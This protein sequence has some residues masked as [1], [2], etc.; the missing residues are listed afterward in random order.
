M[1]GT[2]REVM[3]GQAECVQEDETVL[4]A[5]RTTS[6]LGVGALPIGDDDRLEGVLPDRDI[7]LR[8]PVVDEQQ[9]AGVLSGALVAEDATP[10]LVVS[11]VHGVR[12]D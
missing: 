3:T 10:E 1:E 6:Q 5:D 9:L 8:L 4:D 11:V 12:R 2:A 7:V